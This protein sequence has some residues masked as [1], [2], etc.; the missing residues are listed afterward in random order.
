M[1]NFESELI[2]AKVGIQIYTI[3]EI[4]NQDLAG[5]IQMIAE[6]GYDGVEFDA[7]ML[8]RANPQQLKAWLNQANLAAIGTTLLLP[9]IDTLLHQMIVYAIITGSEWIV[10]PWIDQEQR[11]NLADYKKIAEI[12]NSAGR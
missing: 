2:M 8:N 10:M 3:R 1:N 9:E 7:G 4:A 5:A 12:L 6:A 11:N